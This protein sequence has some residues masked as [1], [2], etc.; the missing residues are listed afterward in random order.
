MVLDQVGNGVD[1]A[2]DGTAVVIFPAE[3]LP[4]G[5]LLIPRDVQRVADQLLNALILRGR[6]GD[7]RHA[8]QLLHGVDVDRAAI[9]PHLVHH[10]Q[11]DDDGR[12]HF[13]KLHREV[14]IPLYISRVHDVDDRF[15]LLFDDKIA[16]DD[17]LAAVGRHRVNARQIRHQGL[18][19]LADRA[20][21]AV[22]RDAREIADVLIGACQLVEQRRLAAV[23][24]P[25]EGK[26]QRRPLRQRMAGALRVEF[27]AL[28]EPGVRVLVNRQR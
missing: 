6:D 23:L 7:D 22:H 28:S 24:V 1:A 27:A 10:I 13:Q 9:C 21:L 26:C 15:R 12:I 5:L 4:R 14:Q 8:E 25:Y 16:G 18:R 17:L 2:V 3:I 19:V 20:V 11:R